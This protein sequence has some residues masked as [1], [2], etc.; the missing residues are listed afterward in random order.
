MIVSMCLFQ[1]FYFIFHVMSNDNEFSPSV[2]ILTFGP[3][4]DFNKIRNVGIVQK[5]LI[6]QSLD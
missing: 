2:F 3:E 4:E 6:S 5:L 1:Y